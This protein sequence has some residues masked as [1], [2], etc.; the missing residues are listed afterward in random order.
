V[1]SPVAP[2]L[3]AAFERERKDARAAR[4]GDAAAARTQTVRMYGRLAA[5][6]GE[7]IA[8]DGIA[9]A[10]AR[11]CD[12]CCHLRVEIRPHDAF[13]LAHHVQTRFSA[14]QRA[15]T[16]A[17]IEENLRRIAPL[18][19]EQHIRAGM[20]CALLEDG[21]CTAYE[22]RPA[23]CR[24][25]HSVSVQTCRD[26]LDDPAAPLT[27]EIEH[28]Q[29]RLAGNAVALGYAKGLDDAGYDAALYELHY[30]LHYALSNPKAEAR[31]RN[32]KRPFV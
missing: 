27:G 4:P 2:E 31:W 30:A 17:R 9:L 16:L 3:R 13:V 8:R 24:K 26:S 1:N 12:Y 14:E 20:P 6:Q 21:V 32:R 18:A 23:T 19:P 7:V 11:G 22:A 5:L 25:Y 10:C 28:E 29:V 15:R